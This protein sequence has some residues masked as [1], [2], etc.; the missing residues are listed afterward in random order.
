MFECSLS[1][2][3]CKISKTRSLLCTGCN[4]ETSRSAERRTNPIHNV[5]FAIGG[6]DRKHTYAAFAKIPSASLTLQLTSC[7]M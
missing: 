6:Y 5:V 7:V 3:S 4:L 1:G 2:Y